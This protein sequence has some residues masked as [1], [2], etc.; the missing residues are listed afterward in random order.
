MPFCSIHAERNIGV[1]DA[2]VRIFADGTVTS[3]W[4]EI[5]T[6]GCAMHMRAFPFDEHECKE[7]FA[8]WTYPDSMVCCLFKSAIIAF[9]SLHC[10]NGAPIGES[11]PQAVLVRICS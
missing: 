3:T 5:V 11:I 9:N 4:Q 7:T 1:T 10:T 2:R 8:S 6:F